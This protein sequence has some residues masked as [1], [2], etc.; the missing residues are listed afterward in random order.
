MDFTSRKL[1][2]KSVND[3]SN[4][5]NDFFQRGKKQMQLISLG[6]SK[7]HKVKREAP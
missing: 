4:A 2:L 6:K 3:L 7:K 1:N 5:V